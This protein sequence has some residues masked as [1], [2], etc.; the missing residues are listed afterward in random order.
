MKTRF[1]VLIALCLIGRSAI[2]QNIQVYNGDYTLNSI[3]AV[4]TAKYSYYENE[5][6]QRIYNGDFTLS[7]EKGNFTCVI[8]GKFKNDLRDGKW[9]IKGNF[10]YP[11]N[12][13]IFMN[14]NYINGQPN[15][16]WTATSKKGDKIIDSDKRVLSNGLL[17]DVWEYSNT[18]LKSKLLMK[19][20]KDGVAMES[21]MIQ[22]GETERISKFKVGYEILTVAKN[23][24]TGE[25]NVKKVDDENI[26]EALSKIERCSKNYPDSLLD[27]PYKLEKKSGIDDLGDYLDTPYLLTFTKDIRGAVTYDGHQFYGL[28]ET[29]LVPQKTR[30]QIRIE[31]EKKIAEQKIEEEKKQL[32]EKRKRLADEASKIIDI[33]T[34]DNNLYQG[35]LS[36]IN[37][38][39]SMFL[40]NT[41][42][43]KYESP[44][45]FTFSVEFTWSPKELK[46]FLLEYPNKSER[47]QAF[48][49]NNVTPFL[50]YQPKYSID[51]ASVPESFKNVFETNKL[52]N[53]EKEF[54]G[55]KYKMAVSAKYE[56][57]KI[58]YITSNVSIKLNKEKEITW[59]TEIPENHKKI[60]EEK[61][62]QLEKGKYSINYRIGLLNENVVEASIE[63]TII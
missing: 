24:Q 17:I 5:N 54:E 47:V 23:I 45:S 3:S 53:I 58:E 51:K 34:F 50:Y 14:I 35:I 7:V 55:E 1:L 57:I 62:K 60:I 12:M 20:D 37:S 9:T 33:K 26:L 32:E 10:G 39:C 8:T 31:E 40:T 2:G 15:G 49:A 63:Q 59:V 42:K 29:E 11:Q 36:D 61:I 38:N 43:D 56:G 21:D 48:L 6:Y 30:E 19:F 4:G 41:I 16:I 27:I 18:E 44:L 46:G 28:Y 25:S 13:D 22:A 52:T